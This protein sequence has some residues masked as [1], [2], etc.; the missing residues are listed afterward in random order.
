MKFIVG[1]SVG[2]AFMVF[3]YSSFGQSSDNAKAYYSVKKSGDLENIIWKRIMSLFSDQ[4]IPINTLDR[5]S[6][7]IL[8]GTVSFIHAYTL[9]SVATEDTSYVMVQPYTISKQLVQPSY[10][11]GQI[12]IF[13]LIDSLNSECR[14]SIESLKAYDCD[15]Y[16]TPKF[17]EDANNQ[18]GRIV[19]ST[20]LLE[21]NIANYVICN[22]DSIK[23]QLVKG[24][25]INPKENRIPLIQK[26]GR[27]I[28]ATVT[29]V[30]LIVFIPLSI[31]L[32]TQVK[33]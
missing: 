13:V 16:Y 14:V 7:F 23:L 5:N 4:D 24:V 26:R 30:G 6:G 3:C 15:G 25:V 28:A 32:A 19:K 10:I 33:K 29:T 9:D 21:K 27:K 17:T 31:V 20:M 8:S 1:F 22:T 2:L 12:K 18:F 11:T